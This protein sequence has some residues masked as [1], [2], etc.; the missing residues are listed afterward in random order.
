MCL[1]PENKM[2]K[3]A[4]LGIKTGFIFFLLIMAVILSSCSLSSSLD[5]NPILLSEDRIQLDPY[6]SEDIFLGVKNNFKENKDFYVILECKTNDC[7]KNVILQ[8]FPSIGIEKDVKGAFPLRV[9]I[10]ENAEKGVYV[11]E[12]V[13]KENG[14]VYGSDVLTVEVKNEVEEKLE[15]IKEE[16]GV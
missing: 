9:I 16:V 4:G 12:L 11:Y 8:T 5:K 10:P 13:V 7:E 15:K 6:Q 2:K 14:N 1:A 3:K